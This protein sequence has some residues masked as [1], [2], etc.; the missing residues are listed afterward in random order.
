MFS[1]R[2]SPTAFGH[3]CWQSLRNTAL[4]RRGRPQPPRGDHEILD[5]AQGRP[6]P[7]RCGTCCGR[8]PAP[9]PRRRAAAATARCT[10]AAGEGHVENLS[11]CCW[12]PAPRWTPG[13]D[14][15]GLSARRI[16]F[17]DVLRVAVRVSNAPRVWSLYMRKRC[18]SPWWV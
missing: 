14:G 18:R 11:G 2:L 16:R 12:R 4:R 6:R 17:S 5:A 1:R 13:G 10:W 3:S 15:S 7:A 8:A 9:R